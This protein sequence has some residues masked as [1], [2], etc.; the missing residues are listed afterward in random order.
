MTSYDLNKMTKNDELINKIFSLSGYHLC[1]W[2]YNPVNNDSKIN[3]VYQEFDGINFH[4]FEWP[5][6]F[7]SH[8]T[9]NHYSLAVNELIKNHKTIDKKL[10]FKELG[11]WFR[12]I[13]RFVQEKNIYEGIVKE[14][15][16]EYLTD[17]VL[18]NRTLELSAYDEGLD[19]FS[20]VARTDAQGKIT[21][22]NNEFCRL[23]KYSYEELL[24]RD[25]RIVNS[26]YHPKAFFKEMWD[27]IKNG[28]SWRGLVKNRAKDGTFY[29]VD[30]IVIPIRDECGKLVEMLSFR[31]DVTLMMNYQEEINRLK[32][33]I[34][35]LKIEFSGKD[36]KNT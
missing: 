1:Y 15:T 29:W 4:D 12:I 13:T 32:N 14:I 11:K 30:T 8:E 28:N 31:F 5:K 22:A 27:S 3:S 7:I 2:E 10:E 33:E 23:S 34:S 17:I 35:M 18:R 26:G 19:K 36:R 24:G 6:R 9:W 20:I 16:S 21:Y 25:H